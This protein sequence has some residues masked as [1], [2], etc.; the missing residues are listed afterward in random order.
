MTWVLGWPLTIEYAQEYVREHRVLPN[1]EDPDL[2]LSAACEHI[3]RK[4]G[5]DHLATLACWVNNECGVVLGICIDRKARTAAE[6]KPRLSRMPTEA[7]AYRLASLLKV[8]N[9]PEWYRYDD[10]TYTPWDGELFANPNDDSD[11]TDSEEDYLEEEYDEEECV[12]EEYGEGP[13]VVE[14]EEFA[15]EKGAVMRYVLWECHLYQWKL[16]LYIALCTVCC[17]NIRYKL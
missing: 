15:N 3:D 14:T 12:D 2:I 4:V 5:D 10:G 9:D 6:A 8:H 13:D 7:A 17:R 1:V 11:D 16:I